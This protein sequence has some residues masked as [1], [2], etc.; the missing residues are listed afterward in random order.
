MNNLKKLLKIKY[1]KLLN[2]YYKLRF[3][4]RAFYKKESFSHLLWILIRGDD[5]LHKK[6]DMKEDSIFFDIG[7]FEGKFTDK[8]LKEFNCHSLIFEPNPIYFEKLKDK[9]KNHEKVK[10]F[11]YGL[12]A[13]NQDLYLID[14]NESSKIVDYKTNYRISVKDINEVI[15]DLGIVKIDLLKLNIEGAEYELLDYLIETKKIEIVESIQVQFHN[16]IRFYENY[17]NKIRKYLS[18]THKEVW[19]YYLIWER[20]DKKNFL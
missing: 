2:I 20:W 16:N 10:V 4:I 1:P 14:E 19:S 5:R 3:F 6:Y 11:G 8:I 12:G 13:S 15:D 9:Y 17:R 18:E 7:G